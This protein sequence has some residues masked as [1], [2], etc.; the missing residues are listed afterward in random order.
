MTK[1]LYVKQIIRIIADLLIE[2]ANAL[3]ASTFNFLEASGFC[4]I[5]SGNL[6]AAAWMRTSG[7]FSFMKLSIFSIFVR[8]TLTRFSPALKIRIGTKLN[9][10][11]IYVIAK[12]LY[13]H[14]AH[15]I[16]VIKIHW[17]RI[18]DTRID[19]YHQYNCNFVKPKSIESII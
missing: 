10:W 15:T 5:L 8:S 2:E 7:L 12:F 18:Q 1:Y 3:V 11:K 13:F 16:S 4:C 17:I 9:S 19:V 6:C 14:T